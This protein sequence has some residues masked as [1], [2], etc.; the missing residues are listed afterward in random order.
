M[1]EKDILKR[2]LKLKPVYNKAN[3]QMNVVL[4]KKQLNSLTKGK[5]LSEIK[6]KLISF[7]FKK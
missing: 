2:F 4:P 6:L 1:P 7:K 5:T 3:G